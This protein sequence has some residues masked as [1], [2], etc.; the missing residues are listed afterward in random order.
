MDNLSRFQNRPLSRQRD[1]S[2]VF[3]VDW[4]LTL[5]ASLAVILY[6]G[7]A[8][9]H[10]VT[11]ILEWALWRRANVKIY[12]EALRVSPLAGRVFFKSLTLVHRD[13][14]ITILEGK[15]TWRY[16]LLKSRSNELEVG[17]SP[18]SRIR[19][20]LLPCR[21][22][23]ECNGCELFMYNRTTAYENILNML[24]KEER[25]SFESAAAGNS[26]TDTSRTAT[27]EKDKKA[28][29][30]FANSTESLPT[31]EMES[32]N[33]YLSSQKT[34][35]ND[36]RHRLPL[37]LRFLPIQFIIIKGSLLIG[38]K[39][40]PTLAI[41]NFQTAKGL[42]NCAEASYKDDLYKFKVNIEFSHFYTSI[43][44]NIGYDNEAITKFKFDKNKISRLWQRFIKVVTYLN[45]RLR[46]FGNIMEKPPTDPFIER[47][48]G[49]SIYQN[50]FPWDRKDEI[51]DIEFDFL[52]HEYAK[53]TNILRSSRVRFSLEMDIP[54]KVARDTYLLNDENGNYSSPKYNMEVKIYGGSV[55]Y[56]PWAQ[57]QVSMLLSILA[58]T[59]ARDTKAVEKITAGS[60]RVYTDLKIRINIMDHVTW[61][62]ATREPSKDPDFLHQY[63]E[64]GDDYRPFGWVDLR[65]AQDSHVTFSLTVCP[66]STGYKNFIDCHFTKVE[67]RTSVNHDIFL[68]SQSLDFQG[69]VG[70][71]L[72]WNDEAIW[73]LV[74]GS[75]QIELFP[76]R[77]HITLIADTLT[78][79]A[80]GEPVPYELFRPFIYKLKWEMIGYSIYLNVND[81]NIVNNP[82]DFNENCYL[83]IHGDDLLVNVVVPR[84]T[85]TA[86]HMNISF[87]ISTAMFRLL[88]NTPPW[89]TLHEF[90]KYKEVGRS[91]DFSLTGNYL[92][93]SDLDIDNVD[94]IT[95][96][97]TSQSTALQTYGFVIRYLT[98]F[99]MNYFG[100]FFHFVTSEEYNGAIKTDELADKLFREASSDD[101]SSRSSMTV[102]SSEISRESRKDNKKSPL[103][104][105][106]LTRATNETDIYFVFKVWEGALILP[107]TIYNADPCIAIHFGELIVDLRSCNYYMDILATM[108]NSYFKRYVNKHPNEVYDFVRKQNIYIDTQDGTLSELSIHGHRM[109][110][111]PPKEPTYF[112]DWSFALGDL[113]IDS[114][115]DFIVGLFCCFYKFGFSH[116]DIE[117]ILLYESE[118]IDDMTSVTVKTDNIKIFVHEPLAGVIL[119]FELENIRYSFMDNE[120][121]RYSERLDIRLPELRINVH[122]DNEYPNQ[123]ELLKFRTSL[124]ITNFV[125]ST[126]F[127]SHRKIQQEYIT[128][129]DAPYHRCLFLLGEEYR[130]SYVY[131]ELFG[132]IVPSSSIPPLPTPLTSSN[133]HRILQELLCYDKTIEEQLGGLFETLG[134][135]WKGEWNEQYSD[136]NNSE[137]N[138][139]LDNADESSNLANQIPEGYSANNF[140]VTV[141]YILLDMDP[142]FIT[143]V[144]NIL[145]SFYEESM[146]MTID[147]IEIITIKRLTKLSQDLKSILNLKLHIAY[148]N[149]NWIDCQAGLELYFEK[150]DI[151]LN[152]KDEDYGSN[153]EEEMTMVVKLSSIRSSISDYLMGESEGRPP[154]MSFVLDDVDFWFSTTNK[155]VSSI[156]LGTTDVTLDEPQADWLVKYV[157]SQIIMISDSIKTVLSTSHK[158]LNTQKD[159]IS[160]L[161]AAGE[162]YQISHDPYVITKPAFIMRLSR[163]HVRENGSWKIIT[164]LRHIFTYLPD[165]WNRNANRS[166]KERVFDPAQDARTVFMNVFSN[167]T[168]WEFSDVARSY[169]FGQLFLNENEHNKMDLVKKV[170]K[171]KSDF[172]FVTVY[173]ANYETEHSVSLAK[174]DIILDLTPANNEF[175]I[176][177]EDRIDITGTVGNL[178]LKTNDKLLKVIELAKTFQN[179]ETTI[180]FKNPTIKTVLR[181]TRLNSVIICETCDFQFSLSNTKFTHKTTDAHISLL[182]EDI[183]SISSHSGSMAIYSKSSEIGLKHVN[184]TLFEGRVKDFLITF[185]SESYSNIPTYL[186]SSKCDSLTIKAATST[187]VLVAF[188]TEVKSNISD[189]LDQ[190]E[191]L[192]GTP[193]Q[194]E[195]KPQYTP[196]ITTEQRIGII[197]SLV[198]HNIHLEIM[199]LSPFYVRH[200]VQQ[201][202]IYFNRYSTDNW[203]VNITNTDLF[204]TSNQTTEQYFKLSLNNISVRFNFSIHKAPNNVIADV[205][206]NIALIK[207]TLSEPKRIVRSLLEDEK[208]AYSSIKLIE[209]LKPLFKAPSKTKVEKKPIRRLI[210]TLDIGIQYIGFLVPISFTYFVLEINSIASSLNNTP[211]SSS[212]DRTK[213]TGQFSIE[214]TMLLVKEKL[215]PMELSKV[216]DFSLKVSTLQRLQDNRN[217]FQ[218]ESSHFRVCL[219]PESLARLA[220]GGL[221]LN[222]LLQYYRKHNVFDFWSTHL[223]AKATKLTEDAKKNED[224]DL[225]EFASFHLLSYNFCIGWIFNRSD[226]DPG[227][228][229]GYNRL[230]S[231][232]EKDLGKLTVIDS[233]FSAANGS[234][235]ENFYSQGDEKDKYNRCY[236]PNMQILYW[237]KRKNE[238]NDVF[239]RF[240]GEKLDVNFAT[241]FMDTLEETINSIVYFKEEYQRLVGFKALD[242]NHVSKTESN[243]KPISSVPKFLSNVRSVN[244]SFIYDGGQFNLYSATDMIANTKPSF[245]V[246]SPKVTMDLNYKH[247]IPGEKL[248]YVRCLVTISPTHNTLY[249]GCAPV[250]EEVVKRSRDLIRKHSANRK[251]ASPK[252]ATQN[253]DYKRVLDDFDCVIILTSGEQQLTLSCEPQAKVF[254]DIG[255]ESFSLNMS[256]NTFDEADPLIFSLSLIKTSASIK[257]IFSREASTSFDLGYMNLNFM[258]TH[259]NSLHMFGT[260]FIS[261]VNVFFN[262]KQLQ[263]L[264]LFLDI[265]KLSD[266]IESKSIDKVENENK[267]KSDFMNLPFTEPLYSD[268][269]IPWSFTMITKNINAD[270]DLGPSLGLLS[271][272]LQRA[273]L[274]TDHY[275]RGRHIIHAFITSFKL[276]AKGRLGGNVDIPSASWISEVN[277][278]ELGSSD[279]DSPLATISVNVDT[280][281]VKAAFD[282]HLFLIGTASQIRFNLH[283]ERDML[284][285]S[286]DLLKVKVS[287]NEIQVS[288]TAL[289]AANMLDIYNTVARMRQDNKVSYIESLNELNTQRTKEPTRYNDILRS[290]KLLQT[291][292]TVDVNKLNVQISPISLFDLDVVIIEIHFIS[293][294]SETNSAEK[295]RTDLHMQIYEARL[296]LSSRKGELDEESSSSITPREYLQK[297][298]PLK[299]GTIIK[300]PKLEINMTTLQEQNSNVLE[301]LYSCTFE[302][303][304]A[305]RWNLGPVNF[306]KEMWK[307]HIKALAVRTSRDPSVTQ[308][309]YDDVER[310][311]LEKARSSKFKYIALEE[312]HIEMPQI[313]DLGDATPPLEWFGINRKRLPAFTHQTAVISIQTMV[314]EAQK[315]YAKLLGNSQ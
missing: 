142:S 34:S 3:L 84:E 229:L 164:R 128:L 197:A 15:I 180:K 263:N 129:H 18:T 257:H 53:F 2:W 74:L 233:F 181:P 264:Y 42:I 296:A 54:G 183:K 212:S 114:S 209:T 277:W 43:K 46:K 254:A 225:F 159:L 7:R 204:L 48:R 290:L 63:R 36:S 139:D 189:L 131:N 118:I 39:F 297:S 274:A 307:T 133:V 80:S 146:V 213:L 14:T 261:D 33:R 21:F 119:N 121:E 98:N 227:L 113:L 93:Y 62:I 195:K 265:W 109:Y 291:D 112:C 232:Y 311:I 17:A 8:Y 272:R 78:D 228:L 99:K 50:G 289:V 136:G 201:L 89:N 157:D 111:L 298:G 86:K 269:R 299:G 302:K 22:L 226:S 214:N 199:P 285:V 75:N 245:T 235:S 279:I 64:T 52:G 30:T 40:T 280:I 65:V 4:I 79:F 222:H 125:H 221:Q 208:L 283:S 314:H 186:L 286:P 49:L 5:V 132:S 45:P 273:W 315:Q 175:V 306:M 246:I 29:E 267:N 218:V 1:F 47:W 282:Y 182:W 176:Q 67:V 94:T 72:G 281:A 301:Y 13:Y 105:Q 156:S 258:F 24:S 211:L 92:I 120:N 140:V 284:T 130:N 196:I 138:E 76:L 102:Q 312:P 210:W 308:N 268:N 141:H 223:F 166:L 81:H 10:V 220:W 55:C 262:L 35:D 69:D 250:I 70:F 310:I 103:N 91:Y 124:D 127:L 116:E 106:D 150:M 122:K 41:I 110:G 230:F 19:N 26:D 187:E 58:P 28:Y 249:S 271:L 295:L 303:K 126:K 194:M 134:N 231:A 135:K 205:A 60:L 275:N 238:L 207:L 293:A 206:V 117:N 97:C 276:V 256:T 309:D 162:F 241:T 95:V 244:L 198:F 25:A 143:M 71:P 44:P 153:R 305:V 178:S 251:P 255:F 147:R 160:R 190:F 239:V 20:V 68:K 173:G 155:L 234:S 148:L 149:F 87:D 9:A 237:L 32:I 51:H 56:G 108:S 167:W 83:S 292:L 168:N 288:S 59:V 77:E 158:K 163:G 170:V 266:L 294:R 252:S 37:F 100:E 203:L 184:T 260:G 179:T 38:N 27:M 154:A 270:V 247:A 202:D 253:I 248:H 151:D 172:I 174:S 240:H 300:I 107:E 152:K 12:I 16:W 215:L 169:I 287:F 177:N 57:R 278:K 304:I 6:L 216:L 115:V 88:L 192:Q 188:I 123:P 11:F 85:I 165:D 90:M 200:E 101:V 191:F 185:A 66:T 145:K 259:P 243:E 96:E 73:D 171:L 144:D 242:N 82:L 137:S 313:K 193:Q 31:S 219:S 236:L 61:R 161:T 104:S 23:F 217:S 224:S